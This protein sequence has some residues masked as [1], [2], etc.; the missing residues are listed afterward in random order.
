MQVEQLIAITGPSWIFPPGECLRW[1]ALHAIEENSTNV[2]LY[3]VHIS[4]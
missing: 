3:N 2:D 1:R 4:S